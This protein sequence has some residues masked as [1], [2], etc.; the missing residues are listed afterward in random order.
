LAYFDEQFGIFGPSGP[1]N[2]CCPLAVV[3]LAII[4]LMGA[5]WWRTRGT[6]PP[7][8]FRR[9]THNMPCLPTLFS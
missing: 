4:V 9:G 7:D 3:Q 6:C 8:F 5:I 2:P 1:G